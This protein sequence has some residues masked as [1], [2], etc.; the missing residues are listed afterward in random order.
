MHMRAG[1]M[2]CPAWHQVGSGGSW[3][4]AIRLGHG[5][6]RALCAGGLEGVSVAPLAACNGPPNWASASPCRVSPS[7][8]CPALALGDSSQ[9]S[10][11][12]AGR[13]PALYSS[14]LGLQ[15]PVKFSAIKKDLCTAAPGPRP[16]LCP[17]FWL[18]QRLVSPPRPP[19]LGG[20]GVDAAPP[21]GSTG[22]EQMGAKE[23]SPVGD[24]QSSPPSQE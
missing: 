24:S 8:L 11:G 12:P 3:R 2:G 14:V 9:F 7:V 1:G 15:H 4:S 13:M 22:L 19:G 23:L 5:R 18:A 16:S 20:G 10:Q 17:C 21:G 6:L